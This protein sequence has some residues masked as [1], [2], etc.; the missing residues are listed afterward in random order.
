MSITSPSARPSP[1]AGR[2][3][4]RDFTFEACSGFTQVTARPVAQPPKAAFVTRLRP[5]QL[6]SQTARHLPDLSTII[7]VDSS[8]IGYPCLFG[9][10]QLSGDKLPSLPMALQIGLFGHGGAPFD[11]RPIPASHAG[12]AGARPDRTIPLAD[13]RRSL[14]HGTGS[15]GTPH[16]K[17][18]DNS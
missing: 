4:I 16:D 18:A 5:S 12:G 6:P 10:H 8:S 2:V 11:T 1:I 7:W 14:F 15:A 3:G 9:A 17:K 13:V